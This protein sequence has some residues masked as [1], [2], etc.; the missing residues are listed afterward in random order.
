MAPPPAPIPDF[1]Q[2]YQDRPAW[3][4]GRPQPAMIRL[5]EQGVICGRVL[6]LGCGTGETALYLAGQGYDV[7][8]VDIA[9]TAITKARQKAVD[10]QVAATFHCH[11]AFHLAGLGQRFDTVVEVGVLHVYAGDQRRA[12]IDSIANVLTPGGRYAFLCFSNRQP[13]DLP[14]HRLT[15]DEIVTAFT[16]GWQ[17]EQLEPATYETQAAYG[18]AAAWLVVVRRTD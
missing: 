18:H 15:R 4:I 2:A 12:L 10:R 3:D 6:D 13:G 7:V 11:D 14:P 9:A 17:L 1:D 16:A 8:G 5:A